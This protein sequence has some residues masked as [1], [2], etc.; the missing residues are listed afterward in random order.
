MTKLTLFYLENKFKSLIIF[1]NDNHA[2]V[3]SLLNVAQFDI[4]DQIDA[5]K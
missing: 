4:I 3:L 1:T 2:D 5:A